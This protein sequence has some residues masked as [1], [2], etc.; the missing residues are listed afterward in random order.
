MIKRRDV[1]K[2]MHYYAIIIA[3]NI[4]INELQGRM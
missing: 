4:F 2:I 3:K 1:G